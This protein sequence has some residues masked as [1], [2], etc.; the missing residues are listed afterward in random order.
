MRRGQRSKKYGTFFAAVFIGPSWSSEMTFCSFGVYPRFKQP[1]L[2]VAPALTVYWHTRHALTLAV[3]NGRS[4]VVALHVVLHVLYCNTARTVVETFDRVVGKYRG[5]GHSNGRAPS[6]ITSLQRRCSYGEFS[7]FASCLN[8][9][10]SSSYAHRTCVQL[11][12]RTTSWHI[13]L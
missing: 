12:L 10:R 4:P 11:S 2:R 7:P 13:S 8:H 5:P 9:R 3:R 6:P 1:S